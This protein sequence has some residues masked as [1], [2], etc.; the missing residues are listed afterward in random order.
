MR[1]EVQAR[2]EVSRSMFCAW[3]GFQIFSFGVGAS[4]QG[5]RNSRDPLCL[6]RSEKQ[7]ALG[8][9]LARS[10]TRPGSS[11][12]SVP[13]PVFG[14]RVYWSSHRRWNEPRTYGVHIDFAGGQT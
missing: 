8:Y 2:A 9:V 7:H 5:Q 11:L 14:F 3:E 13:M 4:V 12:Q 6:W 10:E 1:D